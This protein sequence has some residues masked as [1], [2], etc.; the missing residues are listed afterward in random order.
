MKAV[1]LSALRTGR[2]YPQEIILVFISVRGWV[3]PRAIVQPEGLCQWKIPTTPG[4]EFATFWLVAQCL[5]Q[6]RYRV[7]PSQSVHVVKVSLFSTFFSNKF[8]LPAHYFVLTFILLLLISQGKKVMVYQP[9]ELLA[10]RSNILTIHLIY[11]L[12]HFF[13]TAHITT[14]LRKSQFYLPALST[15]WHNPFPSWVDHTTSYDSTL[16]CA[17]VLTAGWLPSEYRPS[18]SPPQFLPHDFLPTAGRQ[19][20]PEVGCVEPSP[21]ATARLQ[22]DINSINSVL[23]H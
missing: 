4:I 19:G 20:D 23:P 3:N 5:N 21:Y 11:C 14:A 9:L 1:R 13:N 15:Y 16:T 8:V 2:L 22:S 12:F 17:V 18:P 7:P 10:G 6:L